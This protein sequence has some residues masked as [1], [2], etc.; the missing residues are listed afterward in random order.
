M[1]LLNLTNTRAQ[2]A[3]ASGVIGTINNWIGNTTHGVGVFLT[4]ATETIPV[5]TEPLSYSAFEALSVSSTALPLTANLAD[6]RTH[7]FVTVAVDAVRFRLDGVAPSATVGHLANVG[8]TIILDGRA[9]LDGFRVI[10]VTTDAT[11]SV[12]YANKAVS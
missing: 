11:L 10:R 7:A 6:S 9:E 8:D 2:E 5:E 3:S 12:S 1:P 4:G